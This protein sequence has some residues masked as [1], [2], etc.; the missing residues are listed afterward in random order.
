MAVAFTE[1]ESVR[2]M[3]RA[4][5]PAPMTLISCSSLVTLLIS[6]F[7]MFASILKWVEL[8]NTR[9]SD[10]LPPIA[11]MIVIAF[12]FGSAV[13]LGFGSF[14]TPDTELERVA[15]RRRIKKARRTAK[16]LGSSVIPVLTKD[17]IEARVRV[18]NALRANVP[19][20]KQS[21]S[22]G[23][24]KLLFADLTREPVITDLINKRGLVTFAHIKEAL[25][26]MES[27]E[28]LKEGWL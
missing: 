1:D 23:I 19:V 5:R 24:C 27:N 12:A 25:E 28:V 18:D 11:S 22:D 20:W 9:I 7:L 13:V 6:V 2:D 14:I 16:S 21:D 26:G 17:H 8:P 15:E 4:S 10:D 3:W